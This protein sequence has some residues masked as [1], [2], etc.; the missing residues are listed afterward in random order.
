MPS[1]IIL[2]N[3]NKTCATLPMSARIFCNQ[4][5]FT[6]ISGWVLK[7]TERGREELELK[8]KTNNN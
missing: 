7:R 1:Y 3:I 2:K 5:K 4:R 6:Q 8:W